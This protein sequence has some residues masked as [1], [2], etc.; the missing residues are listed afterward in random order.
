MSKLSALVAEHPNMT[1][2][3]HQSGTGSVVVI[4]GEGDTLTQFCS[5]ICWDSRF[6]FIKIGLIQ[7]VALFIH[8]YGWAQT[9]ADVYESEKSGRDTFVAGHLACGRCLPTE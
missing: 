2:E 7:P 3:N 6:F 4:D 5:L 9:D 8:G 1:D